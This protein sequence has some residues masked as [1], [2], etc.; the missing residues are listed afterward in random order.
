MTTASAEDSLW[1]SYLFEAPVGFKSR[2]WSDE[3]YSEVIFRNCSGPSDPYNVKVQ[4][5]RYR[6]LWPNDDY[7]TKTFTKCFDGYMAQSHGEWTGLPDGRFYFDIAGI[8]GSSEVSVEV[9]F[10][11]NTAAD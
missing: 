6:E 8:G 4:M 3:K 5:H 7:D 11:D 2:T 1:D 10:V 9:V